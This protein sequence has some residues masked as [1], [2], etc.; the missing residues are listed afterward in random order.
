MTRTVKDGPGEPLGDR[1]ADSSEGRF[2]YR[3]EDPSP[4]PRLHQA[5]VFILGRRAQ[6][7]RKL[8]RFGAAVYSKLSIGR[9]ASLPDAGQARRPRTDFISGA[10]VVRNNGYRIAAHNPRL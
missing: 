6:D 10:G 8:L 7:S 4:S 2:E 1:S 5:F 3:S 9:R